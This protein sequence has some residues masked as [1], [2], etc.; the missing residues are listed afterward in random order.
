M[1]SGAWIG[2]FPE[3]GKVLVLRETTLG[4]MDLSKDRS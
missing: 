2:V 4:K 3:E 1:Q